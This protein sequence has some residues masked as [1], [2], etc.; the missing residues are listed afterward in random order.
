MMETK[1][2]KLPIVDEKW[3]EKR[4][5]IDEHNNFSPIEDYPGKKNPPL[6][7]AIIISSIILF[8][9]VKFC[10][11]YQDSDWWQNDRALTEKNISE[12]DS[13]QSHIN[14]VLKYPF[15]PFLPPHSIHRHY[16]HY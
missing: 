5:I 15:N 4:R 7:D 12:C 11:W 10:A 16:H 9:T 2:N 3:E 8:F 14:R 13:T 1:N 6:L